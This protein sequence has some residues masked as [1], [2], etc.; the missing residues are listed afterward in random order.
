MAQERLSI[1]SLLLSVVVAV[2]CLSVCLS[3]GRSV[4]TR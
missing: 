1:P 4:S 3:D 2:V